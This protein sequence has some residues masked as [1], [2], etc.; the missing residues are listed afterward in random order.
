MQIQVTIAASLPGVGSSSA[1]V[2]TMDAVDM[3]V[4]GFCKGQFLQGDRA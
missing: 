1:E 3:L 2:V 4:R